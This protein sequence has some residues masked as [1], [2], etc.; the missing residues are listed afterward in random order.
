M[1][2]NKPC[3]LQLL[4]Q[5]AEG[6]AKIAD[7]TLP[8]RLK[9]FLK[10]RLSPARKRAIKK[11]IAQIIDR[12]ARITG[13]EVVPARPDHAVLAIDLKAG[14]RVR[15]RSRAE[16][17]TTLGRWNDLRGCVFMEEMA[18]YCDTKQ[19]VL[20]PVQRFLDERDYRMK[21]CG[22]L[23]LLEGVMCEGMTEYG[24]CDRSCYFFWRTE[25]LEKIG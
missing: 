4:P 15:V 1:S 2:E 9:L 13:R 23:V 10:R 11:G 3:Q 5:M 20:K 18:R 6:H 19:R 8:K 17:Q 7:L 12:F 25:W 21:K 24:P 14:D 22:G 16:I